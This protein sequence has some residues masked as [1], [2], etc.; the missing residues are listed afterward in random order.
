MK[1]VLGVAVF[2][3]ITLGA[4]SIESPAVSQEIP[5]CVQAD[6]S[7]TAEATTFMIDCVASNSRTLQQAV[8]DENGIRDCPLERDMQYEGCMFES[9]CSYGDW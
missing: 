9:G 6:Y 8:L 1:L 2:T 4:V 7:C 5:R 3:T